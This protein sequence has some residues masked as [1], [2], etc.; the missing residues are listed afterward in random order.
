MTKPLFM[1]KEYRL[2]YLLALLKLI[3]P[4]LIQ[5]HSYEPHRDEFLYLAEGRHM[6][7][8]FMEVPPLLSVFAW[9][10]N[11]FGGGFFWI[12]F[13]PALFGALTYVLVGRLILSFGGGLFALILGVLVFIFGVYLR[14][15]YL[16]Q[17]NFPEIFFWTLMAYGLVRYV[18]TR[19]GLGSP[20]GRPGEEVEMPGAGWEGV[21]EN[22]TREGIEKLGAGR[23]EVGKS[24]T[25]EGAGKLAVGRPG[26]GKRAAG[27][28]FGLYVAGIAFGLGMMS[29]YS[30]AFYSVSLFGGLLLTRQRKILLN[31]HFYFAFG[32]GLLI[33]LPNFL[34]QY[35]HGFPV[36]Y[37]MKELQKTQL[38]YISPTGFLVD[39]LLYNLPCL[40][41]WLTGLFWVSFTQAGRPYRFIGW[42]YLLVVS[43]FVLGHGK[44][45]YDMGAYPVLIAFGAVAL[46]RWAVGRLHFMR[47]VLPA[48]VLVLGYTYITIALPFLPPPRLA[49]YYA[50]SGIARKTGALRWEDLR[51]HPLPQ[52]FAD[53]LSWKEMTQKVA[54][55][56]ASLDSTEKKQT[57]L[58]CDNYGEAGAVNYYGRAYGLPPAY[59]DNASFLYWLPDDFYACN[60]LLLVTDDR[61]EM[62]HAFIH[63][64]ASARLLDS[65]TNPYARE[66][67]SLIVLLKGPNEA[68]RKAFRDKIDGKKFK[69]TASGATSAGAPPSALEEGGKMH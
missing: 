32:I 46:E 67:G 29:K 64:F 53:M 14:M 34:W 19:E 52:D 6:A 39:Q 41:I 68:F 48:V 59:S 56:Y 9:L 40:F 45:Y 66:Y 21:G 17:P 12:K 28:P 58:F 37:H 57:L 5:D 49:A 69:T 50:R 54:K 10:T 1:K 43:L 35:M 23:E 16:F 62:Q 22:E 65:I 31:R 2:L 11:I 36:V 63:A 13:W 27:R 8:G 7:W 4:F 3:L 42:A 26:S 20:G 60:N 24:E 38:Q 47:Y 55:G 51:D 61:E 15:F 33:F 30:V 25:G 44:S 18:Q